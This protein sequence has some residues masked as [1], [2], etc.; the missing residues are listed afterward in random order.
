MTASVVLNRPAHGFAALERNAPVVPFDFSRRALR[1]HDVALDVLFCG[2]CHTDL[3][4]IGPWGQEFP[5]VPGHE[6]VGRV[7]EVG[8]HVSDFAPGDLVAISVIV[9]SCGVCHPCQ[10]HDE[11]YCEAGPTSTYDSID[12]VDGIRTRGGYSD[13]YVADERF[14]HRIPDGLD[15]AGAAPLLCAGVTSFAPMRHWKVG[16]GQTVGVVG[17]GGLGHLGVKFARAM[18]AHVVAFTTSA[19]KTQDALSLGAHEVVLSSDAAAM[20]AQA[21]R[22]DFILDTV[23][24][25]HEINPYL[26]A[27]HYNGVLCAVGIPDALS[28]APYLLA[29]GRRSLASSGAGGTREIR[30]MLE[31]CAEHGIVADVE[32]VG[33]SEINQA[34]ERLRNND[35]RFRFVIDMSRD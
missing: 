16:P 30:E 34:L 2:I 9:D 7:T 18:G 11:T 27:L 4:M 1:D 14:V 29:S 22:F 25:T 23:S 17:I 20:A 24:A 28:P 8:A 19:P 3:H 26:T 21:F 35:V 6:M 15:L 12:R 10:A 33:K 13:T 5:L 31:F 32:V